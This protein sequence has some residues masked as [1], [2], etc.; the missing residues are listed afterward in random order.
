MANRRAVNGQNQLQ[1]LPVF[2]KTE[3]G[4]RNDSK[5]Y[6]KWSI[7]LL[8]RIKRVTRNGHNGYQMAKRVTRIDP[9]S[10]QTWSK[11][12]L[13]MAK[14][15]TQNGY[16][17]RNQKWPKAGL[18]IAKAVL[19]TSKKKEIVKGKKRNQNGLKQKKKKL[20]RGLETAFPT[21]LGT[22]KPIL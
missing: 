17:K 22:A 20:R 6:Q 15:G 8:E 5:R 3:I 19:E 11:E 10:Y 4:T 14:T 9:K 16:Y 12:F 13:E 21:R 7:G 1:S 2:E 18:K